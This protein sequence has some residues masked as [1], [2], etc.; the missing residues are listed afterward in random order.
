M[1]HEPSGDSNL[2]T[3][4]PVGESLDHLKDLSPSDL[5][6]LRRVVLVST[7]DR[8]EVRKRLQSLADEGGRKGE[9]PLLEGALLWLLGRPESAVDSLRR[10]RS[11]RTGGFLFARCLF[12]SG[13][14]KE[15]LEVLPAVLEGHA[16]SVPV[17]AL[18][19]EV[20]ER[21]GHYDDLASRLDN[22][23]K[24]WAKE[25]DYF[26][27]RGVLDEASGNYDQA[28]DHYEKALSLDPDHVRALF[29]LAYYFDLRGEDEMAMEFYERCTRATPPHLH[30]FLNLGVLYEDR[31]EYQKAADC[32][33]R[34]LKADPTHARAKLY[35]KDAEA[36]LHMYYDEDEEKKEDRLQQILRIPVTDF[37]LS[38]RS[39]N[40]LEKMNLFTLGDIIK[41]TESELLAFKNFGE[42]SLAEIKEVLASKGLRL[43]MAREIE[44]KKIGDALTA[45]DDLEPP[46]DDVL[47]RPISEL[48]L[49]VRSRRAMAVLGIQTIGDLTRRSEDE[50]K[51]VKNFGQTSLN[52]IKRKL[53]ELG[54][55]LKSS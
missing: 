15:A 49:S 41:K 28:L 30:A 51:A 6:D 34:V 47:S 11:S 32:F 43:G 20:L 44:E 9:D 52:E 4:V 38:V 22:L 19:L 45:M 29:R 33:Q 27:F 40:C 21:L 53:A 55:G 50:L 17:R 48:E 16:D 8:R 25:P 46:A 35:L 26:Y 1:T 42:T 36:S 14:H 31:G 12:E 37:E 23:A 18:E 5:L 24:A 39:R 3:A 7:P 10:T 2:A 13:R 54:L